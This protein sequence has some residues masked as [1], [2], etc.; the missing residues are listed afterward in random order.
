MLAPTF[1]SPFSQI[2]QGPRERETRAVASF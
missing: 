1:V 2:I